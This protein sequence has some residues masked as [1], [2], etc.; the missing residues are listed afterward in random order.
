MTTMSNGSFT[1]IEASSTSKQRRIYL[2]YVQD[3]RMDQ[4]APTAASCSGSALAR[5]WMASRIPSIRVSTAFLS[6]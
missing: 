2:Y 6:T 3:K 1:F 4:A 5:A